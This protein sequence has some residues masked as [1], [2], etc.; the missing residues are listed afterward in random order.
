MK[1]L[2]NS[3]QE[4]IPSPTRPVPI[5]HNCIVVINKDNKKE[6]IIWECKNVLKS[7]DKIEKINGK[8]CIIHKVEREEKKMNDKE[9][10][11]QLERALDTSEYDVRAFIDQLGFKN[12]IIHLMAQELQ[13]FYYTDNSKKIEKLDIVNKFEDKAWK[14]LQRDLLQDNNQVRE[15]K[16]EI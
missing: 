5:K 6:Q 13:C 9:Y 7:G 1:I 15:M 12:R 11:E 8:W 14:E 2:G 10:I 3:Y 16:S 4:N